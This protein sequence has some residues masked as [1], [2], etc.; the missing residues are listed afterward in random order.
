[1]PFLFSRF[2]ELFEAQ[3]R[4]N[5][6]WF[7]FSIGCLY[8]T[9]VFHQ[10]KY[11]EPSK[12][13]KKQ[14]MTWPTKC[15]ISRE[16]GHPRSPTSCQNWDYVLRYLPI[17]KTLL[18]VLFNWNVRASKFSNFLLSNTNGFPLPWK[19]RA[20]LSGYQLIFAHTW[21]VEAKGAWVFQGA[22]FSAMNWGINSLLYV[23]LIVFVM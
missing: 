1:M 16:N 18:Y 9:P 3:I 20:L 19:I 4:L 10:S 7:C 14:I 8:L 15:H 5:L 6:V 11:P 22:W 17:Y 23:F 2:L 21:A 13:N 12:S